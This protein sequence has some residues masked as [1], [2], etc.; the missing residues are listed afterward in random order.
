[1]REVGVV[2][3][4][5]VGGAGSWVVMSSSGQLD[6]RSC[7]NREDV[8]HHKLRGMIQNFRNDEKHNGKKNK[9]F[10]IF[11][12]MLFNFRY[13]RKAVPYLPTNYRYHTLGTAP[14]AYQTIIKTDPVSYSSQ[15]A[16]SWKRR[17]IGTYRKCRVN[18]KT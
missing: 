5:V 18:Q 7:K 8:E 12:M 6:S 10:D 1:M 9:L 13:W 2:L 16:A 15:W 14:T 11:I 17:V 3:A 4:V